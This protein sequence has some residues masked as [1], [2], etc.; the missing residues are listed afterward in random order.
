MFPYWMEKISQ[1]TNTREVHSVTMMDQHRHK[2]TMF[3]NKN[4]NAVQTT[5]MVG[6]DENDFEG[7]IEN[8]AKVVTKKKN[9]KNKKEFE[10]VEKMK[11]GRRE[12]QRDYLDRK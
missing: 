11:V 1:S 3:Q 8:V 6:G 10:E 4:R 5:K 2:T 7:F 9:V 12:I